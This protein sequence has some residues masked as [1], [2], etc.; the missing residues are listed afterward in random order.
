MVTVS[1]SDSLDQ[2]RSAET[3][4]VATHSQTFLPSPFFLLFTTAPSFSFSTFQAS[5]SSTR[6]MAVSRAAATV[7][8]S[9][10][11]EGGGLSS[12]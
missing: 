12:L 4:T 7:A 1:V 10:V 5:F 9:W 6:D 3:G 11:R 8:S 2:R